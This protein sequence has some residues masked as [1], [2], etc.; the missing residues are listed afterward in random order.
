VT[1]LAQKLLTTIVIAGVPAKMQATVKNARGVDCALHTWETGSPPRAVCVLF[2]G[3]ATHGKYP[4][5]RYLAEL[6]SSHGFA[7][8]SMDFEGHGV[9][10]GLPGLIYSYTY[11]TDDGIAIARHAREKF[12][13]VPVFLAGTSMGAAIA[14]NVSRKWS[15]CAGLILLS[16]MIKITKAPPGWQVPLLRA[17]S[18]FA[19]G[20]ALLP[21]SNLSPEAQYRDSERRAECEAD[22]SGYSGAMRLATAHSCLMTAQELHEHLEEVNV[23]FACFFGTA[24]VVTDVTGGEEL[25]ARASTQDADKRLHK[26]EG[27][28]HGLLCEPLPLRAEI[29]RDILTWVQERACV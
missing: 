13:D 26:Y 9:S 20:A 16:P 5:V 27:A 3:Y 14:L 22:T 10:P 6:L 19:P 1:D 18:W 17:I 28:L 23:P 8:M 7:C 25:V 21:Q 2:H 11:L 29:E 12:P 24:D 4:T 15:D